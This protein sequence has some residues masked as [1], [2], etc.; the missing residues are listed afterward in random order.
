MSELDPSSGEI[1]SQA[2]S[3]AEDS[4][5]LSQSPAID[6]KRRCG[7]RMA[8]IRALENGSTLLDG[9]PLAAHWSLPESIALVPTVTMGHHW[10]LHV[11]GVRHTNVTC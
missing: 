6:E 10:R 9:R 1:E 8:P 7:N 2:S 3:A 4:Y 11:T 5:E